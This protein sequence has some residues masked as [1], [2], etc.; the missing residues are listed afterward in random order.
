M[1][2]EIARRFLIIAMSLGVIAGNS[3]EFKEL[4]EDAVGMGRVDG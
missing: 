1:A 4:F 3:G 2:I